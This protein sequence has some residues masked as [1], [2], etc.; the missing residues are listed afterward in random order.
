MRARVQGGNPYILALFKAVTTSD[1]TKGAIMPPMADP[2][3]GSAAMPHCHCRIL[4]RQGRIL[5]R[6]GMDNFAKNIVKI[7][8][9][10]AET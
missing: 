8:K 10:F 3:Q 4:C 7:N 9:S 5:L 2:V 1:C 6:E